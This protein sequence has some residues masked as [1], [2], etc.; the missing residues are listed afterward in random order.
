MKALID[1]DII[2]YSVGFA[3][4]Q[5][6]YYVGAVPFKYKADAKEYCERSGIEL[7][8]IKKEVKPEP[9]EYCLHSVKQLIH[10][11]LTET[12]AEE[13]TI[14]LSGEKNFRDDVATI[15]PY[16]GNRD[17]SAKPIHFKEIK[18]YLTDVWEATVTD[19]VEADDA[20]GIAQYQG[21]DTIIASIDKD[22]DMIP[23]RHYNWR[24]KA[25]YEVDEDSA[26]RT[27]YGQLLTGDAVDNI[28]GVPGIGQKTA[29]RIIQRCANEDELFDAVYEQYYSYHLKEGMDDPDNDEEVM[30][31]LMENA[32]LLWIWRK[33]NDEWQPPIRSQLTQKETALQEITFVGD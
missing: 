31:D 30:D 1:G 24:T 32:R 25:L 3:S 13:F 15:K 14:F 9:L 10:S 17:R 29:E 19:G 21:R 8:E 4:D 12:G 11:I 16:K 26:L 2:A 6:S 28:R 33:E 27:F 20:M 7:S 18:E 22:M 5:V 23:G